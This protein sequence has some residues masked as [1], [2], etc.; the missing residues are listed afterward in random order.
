MFLYKFIKVVI[1]FCLIVTF[2]GNVQ[3]APEFL[4]PLVKR[5]TKGYNKCIVY[6]EMKQMYYKKIKNQTT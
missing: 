1:C 4:A 3:T 6:P 2:S 5:D